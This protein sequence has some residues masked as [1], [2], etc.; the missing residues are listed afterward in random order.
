MFIIS[1]HRFLLLFH[2]KSE[3]QESLMVGTVD[4]KTRGQVFE[5]LPGKKD[6]SELG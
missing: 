4:C 3:V 2:P 6:N 5:S 1:Y